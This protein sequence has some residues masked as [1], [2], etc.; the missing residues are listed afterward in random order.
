M[1][2]TVWDTPPNRPT[3]HHHPRHGETTASVGSAPCAPA[4]HHAAHLRA[5]C[6][7]LDTATTVPPTLARHAAAGDPTPSPWPPP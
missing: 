3:G 6:A 1:P 7:H 4:P 2:T 5:L